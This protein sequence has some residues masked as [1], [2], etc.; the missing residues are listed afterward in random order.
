MTSEYKAPFFRGNWI[1]DYPDEESFLAIFYSS[2]PAPPNYT[3]FHDE[4]FDSLY[5][6]AMV[7][8]EESIRYE[9]YRQMD[10]IVIEE[11]PV[12]FLYYDEVLRFISRRV[13][14]LENNALDLL[15]LKRVRLI[16]NEN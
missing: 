10:R 8:S 16:G 2:N 3:S 5:E 13:K 4:E 14:G 12:V 6:R 1:A 15:D 11:A 7:E 9:L